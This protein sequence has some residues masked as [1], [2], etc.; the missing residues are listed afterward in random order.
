MG[1]V[2]SWILVGS[3]G[4]KASKGVACGLAVGHLKEMIDG[5]K[6]V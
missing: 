2:D 4:S 5:V 1:V 3:L 6:K